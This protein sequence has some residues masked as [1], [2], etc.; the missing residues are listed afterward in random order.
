MT[1]AMRPG[2]LLLLAFVLALGAG[3]GGSA[4]VQ[5]T[6]TDLVG[7]SNQAGGPDPV[8]GVDDPGPGETM[9]EFVAAAH[10]N[11]ARA[12]WNML[13]RAS[14]LRVGGTFPVFK[15]KV[16]SDFIGSVGAFVPGEFRVVTSARLGGGLAVASIAGERKPPEGGPAEFETFAAPMYEKGGAWRLEVFG[17]GSL[18]LLVPEERTPLQHVSAAVAVETGQPVI[19]V[20]VWFDGKQYGSPTEGPSPTQMTLFSEPDED[21]EPGDHTMLAVTDLGDTALATSW[22]FIVGPKK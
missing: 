14:Q 8:R 19:R 3:C 6:T 1:R 12:M 16:A 7:D 15:A 11:D 20:G 2:V 9:L 4:T 21:F 22:T 10:R 13:T 5:P 18:T 17:P